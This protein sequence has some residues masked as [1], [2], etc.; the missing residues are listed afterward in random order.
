[1]GCPAS[2]R[3]GE[4]RKN[5]GETGQFGA[6]HENTVGRKHEVKMGRTD[7]LAGRRPISSFLVLGSS[8]SRD[9]TAPR[10]T[11]T[12]RSIREDGTVGKISANNSGFWARICTAFPVL[13]ISSPAVRDGKGLRVTGWMDGKKEWRFQ[14]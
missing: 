14:R 11:P 2:S 10:I 3:D 9:S 12:L 7:W 6:N 1:M 8:C 4:A 5:G 13:I